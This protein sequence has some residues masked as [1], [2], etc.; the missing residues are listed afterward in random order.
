MDNTINIDGKEFSEKTVKEALKKHCN[1]ESD[2]EPKQKR[3]R[4]GCFVAANTKDGSN[5]SYLLGSL[6]LSRTPWDGKTSKVD[7]DGLI[8]WYVRREME[9]IITGLQ[10]LIKD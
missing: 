4:V 8:S 5:C 6:R 3:M 10:D 9:A 2:V 7:K 1:F